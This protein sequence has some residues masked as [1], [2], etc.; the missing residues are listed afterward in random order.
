MAGWE[1]L[2]PC[3]F[4]DRREALRIEDRDIG[5]DL[6]VDFDASFLEASD[7]RAVVFAQRADGG[8]DTR[9]PEL[10]LIHI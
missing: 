7:E 9:N 5:K 1:K 10:S 6:A 3:L 8:A 2:N 4:D